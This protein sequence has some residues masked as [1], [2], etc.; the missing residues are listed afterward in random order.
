MRYYYQMP[1]DK[2]DPYLPN[3]WM[4]CG[5]VNEETKEFYLNHF[6]KFD[7]RFDS[8]G[9]RQPSDF[10]VMIT[11]EFKGNVIGR[12]EIKGYD[13]SD[14]NQPIYEVI[15]FNEETDIVEKFNW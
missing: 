9:V 13:G 1:K 4:C 14:P 6:S 3:Q 15:P 5:G 11:D 12:K 10:R 7:T 2:V 8:M